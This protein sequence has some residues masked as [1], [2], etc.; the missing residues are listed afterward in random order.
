LTKQLDPHAKC[1]QGQAGPSP[2]PSALRSRRHATEE[3][4]CDRQPPKQT[5]EDQRDAQRPPECR[6][7]IQ[8]AAPFERSNAH[9]PATKVVFT[10]PAIS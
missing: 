4:H 9:S 5:Q 1:A 3:R 8:F 7:P 10:R 6:P 2:H